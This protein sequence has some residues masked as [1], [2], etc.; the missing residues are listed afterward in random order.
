MRLRTPT[1]AA[2][3]LPV[4]PDRQSASYQLKLLTPIYGGGVKVHTPD[5]KMPIRAS[6]IRGQ[7]RYWWRFLQRNH[8]DVNKRLDG[9]ELLNKE[10]AIWGGMTGNEESEDPKASCI[11]AEVLALNPITPNIDACAIYE[12]NNSG[13]WKSP[14]T[15]QHGIPS[16]A[17]F[18]GQGDNPD[19]V[20]RDPDNKLP[21]HKVLLTPLSFELKISAVETLT[22]E[23][24]GEVTMALRWWVSFGGIGARTRRGLGSLDCT[25]IAL[26]DAT[27]AKNYNC[28]LLYLRSDSDA[29][30]AWNNAITKLKAFRQGAGIGR[31]GNQG[32]SHWPEADSIRDL[33]K[34]Y[35]VE[36]N[37]AKPPTIIKSHSPSHLAK[38]AFP[39]AAFGLPIGFKFK[40]DSTDRVDSGVHRVTKDPEKSELN[41]EKFSRMASPLILKPMRKDNGFAGIALLMPQR[42][43]AG[44]K[45]KLGSHIIAGWW[46]SKKAKDVPP[47]HKKNPNPLGQPVLR[48]TDALSAF[49]AFFKE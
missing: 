48:G 38:I 39:R 37:S 13:G 4:K 22:A 34:T 46:D 36:K 12:K 29:F 5:T 1:L 14:P 18:P 10:K 49:M 8:P 35:L 3:T 9:L 11:K 40:Q 41:L 31:N 30:T 16:Y 44:M 15:F 26:V 25:D 43:A 28:E 42:Y 7:L 2:P 32:R 6:A 27:E 19:K 20:S 24:W 21:P 45:L 33:E 23:Q 17:L 47:L